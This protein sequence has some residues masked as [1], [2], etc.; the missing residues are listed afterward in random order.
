MILQL[1]IGSLVIVA[2]IVVEAAFIISG[3]QVLRK[4][5]HWLERS[6]RLLKAVI[7]LAGITLWLMVA[8]TIGV[9]LWALVLLQV[10]AFHA[11]EPAV[12]F[13]IVAFTTLGF[14]DVLLADEWRILSGMAAANG[15]LVFAMSAAFLVEFLGR[16]L[17]MERLEPLDQ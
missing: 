8:H 1:V 6:H 10:E 14:G 5:A 12:Y 2:T 3:V 4:L 15:L 9:W 11:L 16:M 13:S 17:R 7:C